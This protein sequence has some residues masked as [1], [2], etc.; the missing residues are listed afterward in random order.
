VTH[1]IRV[2]ADAETE[3]RAAFLW[4]FDRNLS[5]AE[6]FRAEAEHAIKAIAENPDCW[7]RIT[8]AVRGYV[9]PRFPFTIV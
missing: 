2:H 1:E 8:D 5:V 3:L 4:Y 7:P 9:L 6:S